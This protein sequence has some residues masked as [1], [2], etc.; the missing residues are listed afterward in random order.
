MT[1]P[2]VAI[3]GRDVAFQRRRRPQVGSGR[4][5]KDVF[6][7]VISIGLQPCCG[8]C[9]D[10]SGRRQLQQR[11]RQRNATVKEI[12]RVARPARRASPVAR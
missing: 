1:T 11:Q 9:A 3:A 7:T 10:D 4:T 12:M 2:G 8:I 5:I 6:W